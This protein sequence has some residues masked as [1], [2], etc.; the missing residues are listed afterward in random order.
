MCE[1]ARTW[2]GQ[3]PISNTTESF[4]YVKCTVVQMPA[5]DQRPATVKEQD[6]GGCSTGGGGG[7]CLNR[8]R[9]H[10]CGRALPLPP[11]VS[12]MAR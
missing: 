7:A 2:G 8:G 11:R 3:I 12:A 6:E 1:A 9:G 10:R 5:S 4:L